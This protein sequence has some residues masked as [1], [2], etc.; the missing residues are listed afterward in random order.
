MK[1]KLVTL[2][3]AMMLVVA[4]ATSA[5]AAP[6][7]SVA[8][9]TAP[10]IKGEVTSSNGVSVSKENLTVTAVTDVA[11]LDKETAEKLN[12]AYDSINSAGSVAAFIE[13]NT[14]V[15][16]AVAEALKD[17]D[18][19]AEDLAVQSMFD[20][21]LDQNLV[22]DVFKNGGSLKIPFSVPTLK[23]GQVA[24]VLHYVN[25]A[26]EVVP[27]VTADGVVT[28]TFTSLSPVAILVEDAQTNTG[29]GNVESPQT[30]MLGN[31][32][33]AMVAVVACA[34]VL[35]FSVKKARA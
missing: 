10:D 35:F 29:D 33:V 31:Q 2:A 25:G 19:K 9:S 26:W 24:V 23:A 22:N 27:S 11:K 30:G 28:A 8:G 6:V 7:S 18:V 17:T 13:K 1:K 5:M 3:G 12:A 14:A 32:T 34:A 20:V 4:M 21:S 16:N 15:K